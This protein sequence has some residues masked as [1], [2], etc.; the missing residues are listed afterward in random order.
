MIPTT[1]PPIYTITTHARPIPAN[2][3]GPRRD[4][5]RS[6]PPLGGVSF[7]GPDRIADLHL[8]RAIPIDLVIPSTIAPLGPGPP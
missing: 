3:D 6:G 4:P 2:N 1:C 7:G 5:G 8:D